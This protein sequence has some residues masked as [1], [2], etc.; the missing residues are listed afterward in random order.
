MVYDAPCARIQTETLQ[1]TPKLYCANLEDCGGHREL[2]IADYKQH[3]F[4]SQGARIQLRTGHL[5]I[6]M[7]N[8]TKQRHVHNE[9][10]PYDY[11]YRTTLPA[12]VRVGAQEHDGFASVS[13]TG[14]LTTTG[15]LHLYV[16]REEQDYHRM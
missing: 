5:Q 1:Q 10:R 12:S 14:L 9:S 13:I 15:K 2:P 8:D 4:H 11:G 7:F 16:W 6:H 3:G